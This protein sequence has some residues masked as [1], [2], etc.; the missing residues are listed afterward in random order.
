MHSFVAMVQH[1][2]VA[3]NGLLLMTARCSHVWCQDCASW[4]GA[5]GI[6]LMS[7]KAK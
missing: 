4:R 3:T 1:K 6:R 7:D 2:V 5:V